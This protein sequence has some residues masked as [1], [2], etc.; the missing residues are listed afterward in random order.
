MDE[1]N[2]QRARDAIRV[3]VSSLQIQVD[4]ERLTPSLREEIVH[5]LEVHEQALEQ[6]SLDVPF[7]EE[8]DRL[9]DKIDEHWSR[10][11]KSCID[12]S[13]LVA[14]IGQYQLFLTQLLLAEYT[15]AVLTDRR[16]IG[17]LHQAASHIERVGK[18]RSS[19]F[20]E[21]Y[22][23]NIAQPI[24]ELLLNNAHVQIR[25]LISAADDEQKRPLGG[26]VQYLIEW[27]DWN[28]L[29]KYVYNDREL[30]IRLFKYDP[31]IPGLFDGGTREKVLEGI[32]SVQ[33]KYFTNISS[34]DEY[35]LSKYAMGL[36]PPLEKTLDSSR[37]PPAEPAVE[38]KKPMRNGLSARNHGRRIIS[39]ITGGIKSLGTG[40]GHQ[41]GAGQQASVNTTKDERAPLLEEK[42]L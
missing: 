13:H 35:T 1:K 4:Y 22:Y 21:I 37:V 23:E 12:H 38:H 42:K 30:A 40:S 15:G 29:A 6:P 39:A 27:C 18:D 17:W 25:L 20:A 5:A 16:S 36:K 32:T 19:E 34:L 9:Q 10:V 31:I 8:L 7:L 28:D 11:Y 33:E 41:E 26:Y 14:D 24:N 3:R 2:L